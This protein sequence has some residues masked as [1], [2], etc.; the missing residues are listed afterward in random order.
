MQAIAA[1]VQPLR[2]RVRLRAEERRSTPRGCGFSRRSAN[3][4]SP[5][6][7]RSARPRC[8]RTSARRRP[9]GGAGLADRSRGDGRRRR[10]RRAPSQGP[11]AR[12][13]FRAS[14]AARAA[15]GRAAAR[16]PRSPQ[17]SGSTP[18]D[19]GF[20]RHEPSLFSRRRPLS[21]RARPLARGDPL[22]PGRRDMPGRTRRRAGDLS[23]TRA[24][25]CE[26]G[27][28]FHARMF[29]GGWGVAEDPA[30]GSAAAAFAGV[31]ARL[32]PA[33]RRRARSDDRAGLR[34]GTAEPDR[35]RAS[36]SKRARSAPRRSAA[37]SVIV[38]Q[39]LAR[40]LSGPARILEVAELDFVFEPAR[41][42][43]AERQAAS[44]AAHWTRAQRRP[45]PRSSTAA[46][47]FWAGASSRAAPTARLTLRGAYFE[48]D[49]A[50][51]L[52]WRRIRLSRRAGRQLL[53][54]GG[55]ARRGRRL[56]DRRDGPP[57][58]QRRADLFSRRDAG[59]DR[60]FRRQG[61]P[62]GERPPR[63]ARGDRGDGRAR[64]RSAPGWT[65]CSRP[66]ESPA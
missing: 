6:I 57:Y 8:S 23:S 66:S 32:R 47:C 19:I 10:L 4:R 1:R 65:W 5:A 39:R 3:C 62:R 2:D 52:A 33:G 48:T 21:V 40:P 64:P 31:V 28:A 24:K 35:A 58:L 15:R 13:L 30:T 26:T 56:P 54:D 55:A 63:T 29:G 44:I 49:Y 46:C 42:A 25:S 22:A 34:D 45:S 20:D 59:P 38:V 9:A 50:D 12:R 37:R 51:Y 27:S 7:R 14:E 60:R 61:R 36:R 18:D 53:L 17:A 11:G 41:W 16:T 43:F